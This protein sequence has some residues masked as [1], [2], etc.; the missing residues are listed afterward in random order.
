MPSDLQVDNIK[1]GSATKTLAT[2]SS[3]AVTLHSDVT[4]P[5]GHVIQT[6]N[7]TSTSQFNVGAHSTSQFATSGFNCS[8]TPKTTTSKILITLASIVG[9]T[10]STDNWFLIGLKAEGNSIT[11][12]DIGI[13][14]NNPL[15]RANPNT[16]DAH[17]LSGV[18]ATLLQDFNQ[19]NTTDSITITVYVGTSSTQSAGSVHLGGR[20]NGESSYSMLTL[21]EIA[22]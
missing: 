12:T 18:Q 14:S 11:T 7:N 22:Q 6:V 1:D 4:F 17:G 15:V 16:T 19:S 21:Q 5:A 20:D 3:S 13:D 9:G 8:I 2:L 10:F